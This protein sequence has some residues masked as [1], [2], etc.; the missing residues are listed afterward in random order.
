[1]NARRLFALVVTLCSVAF[2]TTSA[3]Q[4][5][6]QV[7]VPLTDPARVASLNLQLTEGSI[8]V[9][10]SDRR[11]VLVTTRGQSA[12]NQRVSGLRQLT[13]APAFSIEE[14]RN[15]VVIAAAKADRAIDFE[16]EVPNRANLKLN[17]NSGAI[18][19]D[20]VEGE[21]EVE[22]VNGPITLNRVGGAIVANSTNHHVKAV[23]TS[24]STQRPTA[25]TSLNGHV[26]VTFP[27]SLKANL[28]LRSD[29]GE[30]FTDFDLTPLQQQAP[31]VEETRREAGRFR[32]EINHEIYGAVNGGGPEIELR[33]FNG[34]V[35]VRRGQ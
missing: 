6:D 23:V 14:E 35:F 31:R 34:N 16:I 17:L 3:R 7:R 9:R 11:D 25:F 19:V 33:T 5:L 28:K 24:L 13:P 10:G 2:V 4:A 22:N 21:L 29:H 18:V 27:A 32:I 1:M 26:D 30:V 8:T 20:G 12:S 15:R